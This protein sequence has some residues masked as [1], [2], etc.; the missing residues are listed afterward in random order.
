MRTLLAM[1]ACMV[2]TYAPPAFADWEWTRWGMSR[3]QAWE[4]SDGRAVQ[5]SPSEKQRRMYRR[6][7]IPVQ[8]PELV[9]DNRFAGIEFQAY[10]LFDVS[11]AKLTCVDLIPKPGYVAVPFLR[12]TLVSAHGQPVSEQR[13]E[14][15]GVV[16]TTSTWVTERD[17]IELQLGGLG[18]KLKFCERANKDAV[19][20]LR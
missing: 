7:F 6:S 11:T 1:A 18:A 2:A 8:V 12:E 17:T 5:P 13:K 14:L 3:T 10:L 16:W 20:E 19:A 4:A 9:A 15:P